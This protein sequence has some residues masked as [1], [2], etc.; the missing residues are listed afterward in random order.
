M[1]TTQNTRTVT[2]GAVAAVCKRRGWRGLNAKPVS[3]VSDN[4]NVHEWVYRYLEAYADRG[5]V[6][7]QAESEGEFFNL[8]YDEKPVMVFIEDYLFG[9]KTLGRL[10]RIRGQ[11]PK[12]PLTLFSVSGIPADMAARYISW[13]RGSYLSLRVS[14]G[15]IRES[16]ETIFDKRR[17]V[18]SA[19][20][21]SVDKY[22][23]LPDIEPHLTHREIEV[24]RCVAEE[25][26][27]KKTAS[28][29]ST[30]ARQ[31]AAVLR[32][33]GTYCR[34][35]GELWTARRQRRAFRSLSGMYCKARPSRLTAS[36]Q[37]ST[38]C[39]PVFTASGTKKRRWPSSC[40]LV[41]QNSGVLGRAVFAFA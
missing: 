18:P 20:R 35:Q 9:E 8:I 28:C 16:L 36:S 3:V 27:A 23:R 33:S 14:E 4:Q 30:A 2:G 11:Y 12:L 39:G 5:Y 22:G 21:E 6:F 41:S 17:I 13:S 15:E 32:V 40:I 19:I 31:S 24:V 37:I 7:Y 34:A 38:L 29:P 10:E 25:K 26:T 1:I